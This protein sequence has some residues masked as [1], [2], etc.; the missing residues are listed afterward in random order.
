MLKFDL[1]EKY[2]KH[3]YEDKEYSDLYEIDYIP[4]DY[5]VNGIAR[6]EITSEGYLNFWIFDKIKTKNCIFL[7]EVNE[8]QLKI[9]TAWFKSKNTEDI[10]EVVSPYPD[11]E[12]SLEVTKDGQQV[13]MTLDIL[14]IDL[15][16]LICL[17]F[18]ERIYTIKDKLL[19]V[20]L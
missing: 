10:F 7:E 2:H 17:G 13:L 3:L 4:H 11:I 18:K 9:Y 14:K 16:D 20:A 19:Q 12:K 1:I 6:K 15:K 8:K 5:T